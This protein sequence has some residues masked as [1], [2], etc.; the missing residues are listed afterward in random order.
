MKPIHGRAT[1][2]TTEAGPTATYRRLDRGITLMSDIA[3]TGTVYVGSAG[4]TTSTGFPLA[5]GGSLNLEVQGTTDVSLIASA[6]GQIV[7][8]IGL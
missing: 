5:P 1:I 2:G 7:H 6:S 3:N 8:W 4:V